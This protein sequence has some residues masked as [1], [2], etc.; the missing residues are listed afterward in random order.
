MGSPNLKSEH[1]RHMLANNIKLL[2]DH[3]QI[4]ENE[5]A[6]RSGVSQKQINNI[7]HARTGCGI[8]ALEAIAKAGRVWPYML[9]HPHFAAI[10][11]NAERYQRLVDSFQQLPP[12]KREL[13][14]A[15][16]LEIK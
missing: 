1:L 6:K 2:L 8:D 11:G 12:S 15:L 9:I 4:S 13:V 3:M 14:E 16:L 7:T 5:L 10:I